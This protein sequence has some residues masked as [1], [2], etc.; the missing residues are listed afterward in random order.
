[1]PIPDFD[2]NG[3][4]PP[5]VGN[6]A[7]NRDCMSPYPCTSQELCTKLGNSGAR[8]QI[9]LGFFELRTALRQLGITSGFQWLDG[10]FT[11]DAE[12]TRG[13]APGDIDVLTYYQ[14]VMLSPK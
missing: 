14:P 3:V 10:S 5:H 1:M 4:L 12:R 13:R 2:H 9:L 8:L 11:E 7:A 6:H